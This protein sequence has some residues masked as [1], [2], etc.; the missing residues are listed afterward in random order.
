MTRA[1]EVHSGMMDT[2]LAMLRS[3]KLCP[4]RRTSCRRRDD[5]KIVGDRFKMLAARAY[6]NKSFEMLEF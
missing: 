3:T 6:R 4:Q 1:T 2:C 5:L